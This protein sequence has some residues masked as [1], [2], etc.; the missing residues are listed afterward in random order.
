M[1]R[2]LILDFTASFHK[3]IGKSLEIVERV[4]LMEDNLSILE[5]KAPLAANYTHAIHGVSWIG[6]AYH[7]CLHF[8]WVLFGFELH[9]LTLQ[10]L[11]DVASFAFNTMRR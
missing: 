1:Q 9:C 10:V 11:E 5:L 2:E 8:T 6:K 7:I 3:A 4:I